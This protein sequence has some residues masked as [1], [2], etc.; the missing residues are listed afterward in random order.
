ML[1]FPEDEYGEIHHIIPESFFI[2]RN[3]N[4][5]IGDMLGDSNDPKNLIK[6][7]PREHFVCH[8]LL[9]KM[10][11]GKHYRKMVKALNCM[12]N[13]ENNN[14]TRYKP[15]SSR[16]YDFC[17]RRYASVQSESVSGEKNPMYGKKRSKD[18]I[19]KQIKSRKKG[20]KP[21]W[22]KGLKSN[23]HLTAEERSLKYGSF[24]EK[25][26]MYN[27]KHS[28]KTKHK[29]SLI[30]LGKPNL[31]ARGK[32]R[33]KEHSSKIS[34]SLKGNMIGEK[35]PLYDHTIFTFVNESL[36]II[37]HST[38][39]NLITKYNLNA[40]AISAITKGKRNIHKGWTC[41]AN[42]F[43]IFKH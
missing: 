8:L 19:E 4:G 26:G 43:D 32:I 40:G 17:R 7:T 10:V 34:D 20:R 33:S 22:N 13:L 3:R 30:K 12:I 36:G 31:K 27:K 21:A 41:E 5:H 6:L 38:K 37:E 18:S 16:V 14:Q 23:A 35:N 42:S 25:N 15:K 2:N 28:E 24:G 11:T 29:Q 1:G 9:I 39:R